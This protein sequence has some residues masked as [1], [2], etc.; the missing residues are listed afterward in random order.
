[1][2]TNR[3]GEIAFRVSDRG[4]LVRSFLSLAPDYHSPQI[5]S[6]LLFEAVA[7]QLGHFFLTHQETM[8]KC[9]AFD[10]SAAKITSS[11]TYFREHISEN[12]DVH[13]VARAM[14][15]SPGYLR[16]L[17]VQVKQAPPK[18]IFADIVIARAKELMMHSDL[19]L[20]EV[21]MNCGFDGYSQFYRAFRNHEG[22]TPSQWMSGER[23]GV[24]N[25]LNVV[26]SKTNRTPS[27]LQVD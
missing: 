25:S 21:A 9:P 20:K 23:Y 12:P 19:S 1:L 24:G 6:L 2:G 4:F 22:V 8:Q 3:A 18:K 5:A 27:A 15:V 7:C 13:A 14:G 11:I 16:A 17:F 26:E 10:P